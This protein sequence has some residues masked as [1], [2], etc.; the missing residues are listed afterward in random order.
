MPDDGPFIKLG[1]IEI[2][3]GLWTDCPRPIKA[4]FYLV[5]L[6]VLAMVSWTRYGRDA[7]GVDVYPLSKMEAA[8]LIESQRHFWEEAEDQFEIDGGHG[9]VKHYASDHCSVIVWTLFDGTQRPVFA[10]HPDREREL[11]VDAE[12]QS[13]RLQN[14]GVVPA[15][16]CPGP[17][18]GCCLDPHPPPW[19]EKT[20]P[21]D[22]CTARVW[23]RFEDG[24]LHYQD[25]N[26]CVRQWGPIVWT[27]C[28]H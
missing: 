10:L 20:Q 13:I 17:G 12:L 3:R 18:P 8:Q 6:A 28:Y 24:C 23:R 15:A 11:D 25:S 1:P 2:P 26:G 22:R 7:L 14:A 21:L 19:S 5:A 9:L 27:E 16:N 4:A